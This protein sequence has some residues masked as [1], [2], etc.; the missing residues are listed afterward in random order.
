MRG[1]TNKETGLF[2]LRA[3]Q[4]HIQWLW[5][6]LSQKKKVNLDLRYQ[7]SSETAM[8]K[9]WQIAAEGTLVPGLDGAEL[10]SFST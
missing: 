5:S 4:W 6:P 9:R 2:V 1:M 8:L 10:G 3:S 7:S